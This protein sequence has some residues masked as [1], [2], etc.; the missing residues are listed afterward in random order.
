MSTAVQEPEPICTGD[1]LLVVVPSPN[2]PEPL[3]PQVNNFPSCLIAP[4]ETPAGNPETAV[5][6]LDP[7]WIGD[8]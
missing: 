3:Y 2:R 6:E 4:T 5:Q 1:E 8:G 7:T